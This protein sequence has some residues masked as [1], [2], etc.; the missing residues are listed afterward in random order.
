M[1]SILTQFLSSRSHHVMLDGCRS[2]LF[3]VVSGV[4]HGSVLGPLLFLMYT[5]ELFFILE[6]KLIGY[7]DDS[8]LMA[9]VPSPGVIITVKESLVRDLG[10]VSEWCDLSGMKLN[11]SKTKTMIVSRSRTMHP[12]S[13][14]LTIGGSVLKESDDL[15]ILGVTFDSKLT[16]EKHLRWVSRAASQRLGILKSSRVFYD[17]SLPERC[18]RVLSCPFWSTVL[19]RCARLPIHNLHYWTVQSVVPGS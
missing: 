12:L 13:P 14:P 9:S 19:Q 4:T 15:V 8:I 11:S 6:N 10:R 1:L 18:F 17:N 7:A 2:K 3:G 16:F 5:S